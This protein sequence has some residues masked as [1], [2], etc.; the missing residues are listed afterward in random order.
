MENTKENAIIFFANHINQEIG[1]RAAMFHAN[2]NS[3]NKEGKTIMSASILADIWEGVF[4]YR[5]FYLKQYEI[6]KIDDNMAINFYKVYSGVEKSIEESREFIEDI[7]GIDNR[8][9]NDS[10]YYLKQNQVALT[11]NGLSIKK[12]IEYGWIKLVE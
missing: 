12:Q 5:D 9:P 3:I 11:F 2:Y 7:K 4:N 10:Y 6:S 1:I 8:L